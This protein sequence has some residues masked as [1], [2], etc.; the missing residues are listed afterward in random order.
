MNRGGDRGRGFDR[1]RGGPRGGGARGGSPSGRGSPAGDGGRGRGRGGPPGEGFRGRGGPP[2]EGFRGRGGFQGDRG[3]GG[4]PGDRGRGAPRGGRGG[5]GFGR[6]QGGVF[7]LGQPANLDARLTDSSQDQLVA[8]LKA[9]TLRHDDLPTRPDY[10]TAG[11]QIKLR[12]NFFPVRVPK[13]PLHEY[14]VSITPSTNTAVK[15]VRRRIFELAERTP[16]WASKGLRGNVAHDWAAKLIAAKPLEQPLTIKILL[17]D[18]DDEV[19][20]DDT[21]EYILT[22]KYIQPI[23]TGNLLKYLEGNPQ[24][25]NFDITPVVAALNL[26][27]SSHASHGGI[28][29]GKNRFFFPSAMPPVSIGGGLEAW[30]GFYSSVRPSFKQLMVNVN[31]CTTAFY[32]EGNLADGMFTFQN[33][34]F[35]ARM[36]AF[37]KGVRVRTEHLGYK[38]TV[39][40][41]SKFTAK[42][43]RFDCEELGGSVTVL[44]YFSQKYQINLK[45]PDLP[46]VD[47]GG[48]K[49]N[50]L[51][52]ELCTILPNQPFRG[53]LLDEHTAQMILHAA[54]PP[55]VN[56]NS[57]TTHGLRELG[58]KQGTPTPMN[59]FGI[60]VGN[61]MTVV[62]GRILTPPRIKYGRGEPAVDERASWNLRGV[63]FA[64]GATL[65]NW[66]VLLIKDGNRDEFEDVNDPSLRQT[67]D[68]FA[69]MCKTSGMRIGTKPPTYAMVNLPRKNPQDPIRS[70]AVG[71]IR[72][73]LLGM[74][75]KPNLVLVILSNGDK[76]VYSGLKHLCD[77]YLDVATVCVQSP[78]IRKEKGQIQY[79]AN[80]A[81]KVN[82]K[83]GGVNHGL[84]EQSMSKLRAVPTML[85]GMDVTH[86]G[87]GTVKGTPSIAAVVASAD[88]KF[89]Q[90]PSSMRIQETKKEMITDLKDMMEERLK[91]YRD[92]NNK[93]LP[94]RV[95]VYRD[96]VS[97]GQFATVIAEEVP[98]MREAFR[99]FDTK[100]GPYQPQLTVVVCAK[101]HH[102]RFYPTEPQHADRDGNPRP[103]TVVDR[104][105]TS[106]YDFDFYL[107]A[108]GGLQGTT[109]PTHYYVIC[110]E[111]NLRADDL[112]GLT[113]A[114]SYTFAR[115]TKAVSLVSPAYYADLACER[116]RCYLHKLL[117]GLSDSGVTSASGS[118]AQDDIWR[119]AEKLWHGGVK[120]K[121]KD[122]MYYL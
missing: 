21:K 70:Q 40:Q 89:A 65:D 5:G 71:A 114:V 119:E 19:V 105:V 63:V 94:Q 47:V 20:T 59:A 106:V 45:Y 55:N 109:R 8:S 104:G 103:G 111:M 80:V 117:Q 46:L 62:P 96:G 3:R 1:G 120:G 14:D 84:D 53:K 38:K 7:A 52:P 31:V 26:V 56:A 88:L 97:E 48:K 68:G 66:A 32:S 112:Q 23:E 113:N 75:P 92:K 61:E 30:K 39:K 100:D 57:I 35:G 37:V 74:K 85:V 95:L 15:R 87:P 98:Q 58:F 10:G 93:T 49:A 25:R 72:G 42:T 76:H 99:K 69:K 78:K 108:H 44:Q 4:P 33:A 9:L 73:A 86:P 60:A 101:R 64:D 118:T 81:L 11:V 12:A 102:T 2:G 41:L 18:D 13:A 22:I 29:V 79:F 116:G 121:L 27:L 110:N 36:S 115:A 6:E 17:T 122:I 34:S 24:H 77:V 82:M 90:Y 67:I 51:P 16:E 54:K 107:Q 28:N 83:L 43:Y 50:L 91:L